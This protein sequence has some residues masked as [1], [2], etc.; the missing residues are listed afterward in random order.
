MS[1]DGTTYTH[2]VTTGRAGL[3]MDINTE[4]RHPFSGAFGNRRIESHPVLK[5]VNVVYVGGT[6]QSYD[7]DELVLGSPGGVNEQLLWWDKA[8]DLFRPGVLLDH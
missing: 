4:Q 3:A 7:S 1:E 2:A 5:R 6:V 8:H